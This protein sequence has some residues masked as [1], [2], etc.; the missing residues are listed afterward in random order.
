M[1]ALDR[2]RQLKIHNR[3]IDTVIY[4]GASDTIIVEGSL[5]DN[6]LLDS[7]HPGGEVRPPYTVHHMVIR[8]EVQVPEL[9]ITDIEVEMP[10]VPNAACSETR[11]CLAPVKGMRIAAGFTSRVRK[12]VGREK[13]C[14]HLLALLAAMAPA[15]FQGAWSARIRNPVD[16]ETYAAMRGQLINTCWA[17]REY[18][19]LVAQLKRKA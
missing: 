17:W 8:M 12:L 19:P 1:I 3:R 11:D 6:R 2:T 9:L 5:Q 18:G 4:A 15:A 13:G 10:S 7:I 16:P 14:T